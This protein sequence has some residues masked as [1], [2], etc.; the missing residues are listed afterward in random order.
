MNGIQI[1]NLRKTYRG[2]DKP[3][4]DGLSMHIREGEI[5][6]LLGP[7]GAGKTTTLSI[8]A[9]LLKPTG[10][11]IYYQRGDS[12][13]D[14]HDMHGR[15]GVVPQNIALYPT[16]TAVE[17]LRFFGAMYRIGKDEMEKQINHHLKL[18]GLDQ[19]SGKQVK[20]FSG[21]MKRRL[22]LIAGLLHQPDI[23]LLDEPT[24][25]VDVQSRNVILDFL[26]KLKGC[27]ATIVYTSHYL[28]EAQK[29]CDH[30]N[31]VDQGR[32]ISSGS[33]QHLMCKEPDCSDLYDLFL[34][35]TGKELRD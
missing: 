22:N 12:R 24:A 13:I 33:P 15:M 16:L 20:A 5:F 8:L 23:L 10:G 21:G 9:G 25:G 18:F 32:T 30:I 34:K 14:L 3:A 26:Q 27:G 19:H 7:N 31:I 35:L 4:V 28:D 17:N 1:E 6:G 29:I 11:S 2:A